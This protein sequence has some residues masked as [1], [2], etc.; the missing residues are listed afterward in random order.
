MIFGVAGCP[1]YVTEYGWV[2]AGEDVELVVEI[3]GVA[4][5]IAY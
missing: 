3:C 1:V 5:F 4:R 2:L